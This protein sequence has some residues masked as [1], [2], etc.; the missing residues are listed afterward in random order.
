MTPLPTCSPRSSYA[1]QTWTCCRRIS[2]HGFPSS[3]GD[4][5]RRIRRSAGRPSAIC[6]PRL[7]RLRR[8]RGSRP[9]P[10]RLSSPTQ[11]LWKRAIP[12][13]ADGDRRWRTLQRGDVVLQ[14]VNDAA[15]CHHAIRVHTRGGPTAD[16]CQPPSDR[17]FT[18]RHEDGLRGQL[19]RIPAFD[20]GAR[21][22]AYPG[23]GRQLKDQPYRT[24][25]FRRMVESI[26]F[27]SGAD[28]TLKRTAVT[29]GAAVT[30]C[31]ATSPF[32]MTWDT[33]GIVFAQAEGIMR[34]S[35][36]WRPT[37]TARRRDGRGRD[38][39]PADVA[40]RTD[41]PVHSS[42]QTRGAAIDGTR[43]ALWRSLS[44]RANARP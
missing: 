40:R 3:S 38:E 44:D 14:T 8:R 20:V 42:A 13:V 10:R 5:W 7:K 32:G 19:S 16:E 17:N 41:S 12:V 31:P 2:T 28:R 36:Q 11:P 29:G 25:P 37:G 34:V 24:P 15:A 22:A 9:R 43:H 4:A 18:G 6:A 33:N 23:H 26:A 1:R 39:Q 35:A 27:W 30:I 21:R